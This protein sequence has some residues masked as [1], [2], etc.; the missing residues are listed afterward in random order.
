MRRESLERHD[1]TAAHL[2]LLTTELAL[3]CYRGDQ[4][5]APESLKQLV[6]KYLQR[7]PTDPFSG[8]PLI[9]RPQGTNWLLY[10]VGPDR[11]DDGGKPA[12]RIITGDPLS[13]FGA[14]KSGGGQ[15]N[16]GDLLY[17]SLW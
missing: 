7:V 17:D 5:G 4:G 1:L 14:T 12:G 15:Q 2:R 3:R 9:Y 10:S 8:H 13:G 6:P 11:A 16:K